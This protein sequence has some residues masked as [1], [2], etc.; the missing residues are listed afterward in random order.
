MS[1]GP[2]ET[3][4][5]QAIAAALTASLP[6]VI[7]QLTD[8]AGPRAYSVATVA[9]RLDVSEPTIYRLIKCGL[10]PTVPHLNPTRIAAA[11]L[12]KFLAADP[13]TLEAAS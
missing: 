13:K 4:I 3:A 2:L 7:D 9:N 1:T 6:G 10:L 5:E 12:E 8:V 11:A